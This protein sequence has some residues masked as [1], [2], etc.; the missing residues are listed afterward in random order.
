MKH[1]QELIRF[2]RYLTQH[3]QPGTTR[4]YCYAVRS[5]FNSANGNGATKE[6][7]QKY[8]DSLVKKGLSASTVALRAHAIMR[9]FKFRGKPISLDCPTIRMPQPKYLT[10]DKVNALLAS[11]SSQ[12][13]LTLITVLFDTAVRISEL[14]NLEL[15][16]IDW[17]GKTVT[18]VRKGGRR[19]EVNVS[20]RAL[21]VLA[22]WIAA[23]PQK[24][25][26]VFG[27]LEY[28]DAWSIVKGIGKRAGISVTPHTLRH[29]R[30]RQMLKSGATLHDVQ[31]HLGH[32]SITT[33]ANIY[34]MF[35]ASDLRERIPS[36]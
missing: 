18:V 12:L 27:S 4:M 34:G 16:D 30:A 36:W 32:S 1:E 31:Q 28:W 10:L 19:Q 35:T 7:A 33:T 23:Q 24:T 29:S 2:E 20:D 3:S 5:W 14:L 9:L 6:S 21:E 22:V 17:N 15:N 25:K 13:E 11:S 8:I 26:M